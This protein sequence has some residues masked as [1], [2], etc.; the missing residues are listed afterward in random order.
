MNV[1][2]RRV[3]ISTASQFGEEAEQGPTENGTSIRDILAESLKL[4]H[5][6][7]ID[8]MQLDRCVSDLRVLR[9]WMEVSSLHV[10]RV[11]LMKDGGTVRDAAVLNPCGVAASLH[12]TIHESAHS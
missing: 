10:V 4:V 7:G 8:G 2:L 5:G 9:S 11:P 3:S 6:G 12:L 1:A